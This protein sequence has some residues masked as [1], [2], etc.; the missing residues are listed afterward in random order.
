MG[1]WVLIIALYGGYNGTSPA[2]TSHEF[3]SRDRC[4]QAAEF[5]HE[6]NFSTSRLRTVCVKK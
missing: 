1:T 4:M 6:S 2:L 5:I 3:S